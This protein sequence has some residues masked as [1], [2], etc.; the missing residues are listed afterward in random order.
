MEGGGKLVTQETLIRSCFFFVCL[1]T[2][3]YYTQ[4]QA[5]S[6]Y[7]KLLDTLAP[8]TK[9]IV[10]LKQVSYREMYGIVGRRRK[11]ITNPE[12][13]VFAGGWL[14]SSLG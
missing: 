3:L 6:N 10:K 7:C 11:K 13:C 2:S 8:E 12:H 9:W 5:Q 4:Y 1:F 14:G